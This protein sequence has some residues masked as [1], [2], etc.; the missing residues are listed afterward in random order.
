MG[1]TVNS[2]KC[3]VY[4]YNLAAAPAAVVVVVVDVAVAVAA[5]AAA[6]AAIFVVAPY[7][8]SNSVFLLQVR[9]F[10]NVVDVVV[11]TCFRGPKISELVMEHVQFSEVSCILLLSKSLTSSHV[12]KLRSVYR[13]GLVPGPRAVSDFYLVL[14]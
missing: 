3:F 6:V 5:V 4:V 2:H 1:S 10:S 7:S 14:I 8:S 12:C 13:P 11:A 9:D